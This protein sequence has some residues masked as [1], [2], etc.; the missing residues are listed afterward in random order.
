MKSKKRPR[1]IT[2]LTRIFNVKAWLDFDRI[3]SFTLYITDGFKTMFLPQKKAKGES[4]AQTIAKFKISEEEL[5]KKQTA[6]R[7]LSFLMCGIALF[8]FAYAIYLMFYGSLKAVLISIILML[9]A[10]VFAF[11]YH[12]W[13]FQI[14][15][16]KLGC[17]IKEWYKEG[18]KSDK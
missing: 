5:A 3:R 14:K 13:Y 7:R 16:R 17:T 8:I 1:I 9:L 18:L 12:F 10:L 15:K 6:L 4:F 11:R 2:A